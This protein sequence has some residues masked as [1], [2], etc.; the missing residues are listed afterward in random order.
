MEKEIPLKFNSLVNPQAE[1]V[2][3]PALAK[4]E[5]MDEGSKKENK[6]KNILDRVKPR[7]NKKTKETTENQKPKEGEEKEEPAQEGERKKRDP[8]L[9]RCNFWPTCKN[10]ECPFVHPS[11]QCPKFPK[12]RFGNK[13]IY[14]HP[15]VSFSF[16]YGIT[17]NLNINTNFKDTMQ[18]WDDVSAT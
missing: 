16:L 4:R 9:T 3:E 8:K 13:C 11:E 14:I 6:E 12:C 7:P 17:H 5:T 2:E 15:S 1:T 18:V 10:N